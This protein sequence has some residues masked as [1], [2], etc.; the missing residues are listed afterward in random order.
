MKKLHRFNATFRQTAVD[1][2]EAIGLQF[3]STPKQVENG[4]LMFNDPQTDAYYAIYESGYVR[5]FIPSFICEPGAQ[6]IDGVMH[7]MYQLN[8]VRKT[9]VRFGDGNTYDHYK[10]VL[11]N[12]DEQLGILAKAVINRRN[13][14]KINKN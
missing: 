14:I 13:K 7:E 9:V 3:V 1:I 5:R 8:K 2:A 10:R 11:A 6:K 12:P 4:T